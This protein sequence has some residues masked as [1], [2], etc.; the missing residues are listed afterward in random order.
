MSDAREPIPT[1]IALFRRTARAMAEDLVD[2]LDT[3][4]HPGITA[5]EHLVFENLSPDGARVTDLAARMGMTRQA[6]S[7]LVES[8]EARGYLT[9][10]ADPDDR[11]ARVVVLTDAGRTLVR[12]ALH[13]IATIEAAWRDRLVAAGLTGDLLPAL[14]AAVEDAEGTRSPLASRPSP[15]DDRRTTTAKEHG[16]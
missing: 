7:E 16:R 2:R 9:R 13:E 8:L 6:A 3:A 1:V 11:R 15:G 12:R 4:G 5:S 14:R 10:H